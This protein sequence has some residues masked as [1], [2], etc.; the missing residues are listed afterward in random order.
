MS[1]HR[2]PFTGAFNVAHEDNCA[3]PEPSYWLWGRESS[4][5]FHFL[6]L[7]SSVKMD[8]SR[9]HR[10][11][12][13]SSSQE[14]KLLTNAVPEKTR[15]ANEFW[16]RTLTSFC[17]EKSIQ[18]S[19]ETCS[20]QELDDCLKKFYFGL[21]TKDGR[22]YQRSSYVSARSAIQRQLA[23][24]KRPFDL[25]SGEQF[26]NSNRVLDAVLKKNK[27]EGQARPVQHKDAISAADKERLDAYFEDVL[28][29]G[30]TY[31]LQSYVWYCF[32]RHFGLRGGDFAWWQCHHQQPH[33]QLGRH[34]LCSW[35]TMFYH[36]VLLPKHVLSPCFTTIYN[37][38]WFLCRWIG[39][40][41]VKHNVK[42]LIQL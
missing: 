8:V 32:A 16:V 7:A 41:A 22:V 36:H 24:F 4:P 30:D 10:F 9:R 26:Q 31:K 25:R 19:L 18:L 21:R 6:S 14:D 39:Q 38:L 1:T 34:E 42:N 28:T 20:A 11:D 40:R 33:H 5:L 12:D 29:S 3:C 35:M 13:M 17:R 15:V 27:A 2:W 23:I 37:L